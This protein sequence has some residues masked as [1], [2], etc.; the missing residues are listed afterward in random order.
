MDWFLKAFRT[1]PLRALLNGLLVVAVLAAA[2]FV[3]QKVSVQVQPGP[4]EPGGF[5]GR[6]YSV[7]Q[8]SCELHWERA[9][10]ECKIKVQK[11]A[12]P[13]TRLASPIIQKCQFATVDDE[14]SYNLVKSDEQCV[15]NHEDLQAWRMRNP[16]LN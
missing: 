13:P 5:P 10:A 14:L 16:D 8:K 9:E 7:P 3:L 1:T 4:C 12:L 6:C 11:L 15:R 2:A